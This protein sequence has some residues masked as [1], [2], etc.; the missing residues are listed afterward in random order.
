MANDV[1]LNDRTNQ[2]F[3]AATDEIGGKHHQ[4]V[5]IEFGVEDA[6]TMVSS[7][8]PLPVALS[9]TPAV[10]VS[11][12]ADVNVTNANPNGQGTMSTSTPVVI[13]SDQTSV[14]MVSGGRGYED[15]AASQTD[16]VLGGS[17]AI[18]D[19]I[20]HILVTPTTTSPGSIV[21]KDNTTAYTVFA[22]GSSSLSNLVPFVI[23]L[24]CNSQSGAWKLTTGAGLSCRCVGRFT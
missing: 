10:S 17:G 2:Q 6:A 1:A 23:P 20:S 24:D 3:L 5:K 19:Y 18:G 9:G 7:S 13:A 11:G 15:V 16:Q 21:L 4:L 12:T 22:G 8:N 14:K